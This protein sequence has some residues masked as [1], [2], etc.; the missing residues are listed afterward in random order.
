MTTDVLITAEQR[1]AEVEAFLDAL[2]WVWDRGLSRE[3]D[4]A[5]IGMEEPDGDP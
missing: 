3:V 4:V 5:I 2:N 1:R